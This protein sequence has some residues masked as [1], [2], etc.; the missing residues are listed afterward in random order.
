MV[1]ERWA[2]FFRRCSKSHHIETESGA[3]SPR[4]YGKLSEKMNHTA[5]NATPSRSRQHPAHHLIVVASPEDADAIERHIISLSDEDRRLRFMGTVSRNAAA[6]RAR[7]L[8]QAGKTPKDAG[9]VLIAR[10]Q[11]GD[12]A[13]MVEAWPEPYAENMTGPVAAGPAPLRNETTSYEIALSV[14][15][16]HRGA[17]L[18]RRLIDAARAC[19][20]DHGCKQSVL[21]TSASNHAMMAIGAHMRAARETTSD[22]IMFIIDEQTE[23]EQYTQA[24]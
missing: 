14:S 2:G 8:V 12:V 9:F 21:I 5:E 15:A 6:K 19:A 13:G 3:L 4:R 16:D 1:G 23:A 10:T 24:A 7:S 22:G 17:G 18:G 11:C 20:R